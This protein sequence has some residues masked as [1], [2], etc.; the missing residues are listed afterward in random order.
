MTGYSGVQQLPDNVRELKPAE[1]VPPPQDPMAMLQEILTRMDRMQEEITAIKA[2]IGATKDA[3]AFITEQVKPTLDML[4]N[5]P[6]GQLLGIAPPS[7]P[8]IR[9]GR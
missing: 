7:P 9:R 1:V 5:G 8:R 4:S 6:I 2:D 3:I